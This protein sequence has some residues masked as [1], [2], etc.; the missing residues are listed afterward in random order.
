MHE[1]YAKGILSANNTMNVYRGCT[2]GCIYCDSRSTCYQM[3]H[4]FEDI[5]V[6]VNAPDLL[7]NTLRRKRKK[8]M[9]HTGAMC[10]PYLQLEEKACLT[11]KC[12]EIIERYGFGVT[13][14]TKS[15]RIL[16]DLDILTKINQKTKCVVQMTLTTFDEKLCRIIEPNVSGTRARVEAL[17]KIHAAGIPTIVWMTPILPFINDTEENIRGLLSYCAAAG[18]HGILLFNMGMTLRNGDR[19]Y[20]YRKLDQHFPG[21][22]KRYQDT[23]GNAY[24][25]VSPNNPRLMGI[26]RTFCKE[27]HLLFGAEPCFSYLDQMEEKDSWTQLTLPFA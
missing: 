15:D 21:I 14:L 8:C 16:R 10:D 2:H 22:K 27:N 20:F 17:K 18:V 12:L 3:N 1:V 9:I 11:R 13:V 26:T 6:K 23:Y 25:I 24:E 4:A 19:E 7:E 5:E